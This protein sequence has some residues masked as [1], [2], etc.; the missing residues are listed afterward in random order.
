[1]K[2]DVFS[3]PDDK[4]RIREQFLIIEYYR[5]FII[6]LCEE[7]CNSTITEMEEEYNKFLE[8]EENG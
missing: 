3:D 5:D 4:R 8:K 1:M 7:E 2:V 6:W